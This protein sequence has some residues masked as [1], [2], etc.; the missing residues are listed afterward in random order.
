MEEHID[1]VQVIILIIHMRYHQAS[2]QFSQQQDGW[3]AVDPRKKHTAQNRSVLD[4]KVMTADLIC[5]LIGNKPIALSF[6]NF[7]S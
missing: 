3:R 7:I 2:V 1:H 6:S 5:L 4:T